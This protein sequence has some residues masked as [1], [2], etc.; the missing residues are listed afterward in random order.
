MTWPSL[1]QDCIDLARCC[2][3]LNIGFLKRKFKDWFLL[4]QCQSF[5]LEQV[6]RT[7][8]GLPVNYIVGLE[9]DHSIHGCGPV[10]GQ[11]P[12]TTSCH[13]YLCWWYSKLSVPYHL[14]NLII[15]VRFLEIYISKF[16]QESSFEW[17]WVL[18]SKVKI[19][20]SFRVHKILSC[21]H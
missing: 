16:D 20:T 3:T 18:Y 15:F 12:A 17:K 11:G 9:V 6:W 5:N 10:V 7:C 4:K 2:A 19:K 1:Q 8:G 14:Y 21:M 13:H